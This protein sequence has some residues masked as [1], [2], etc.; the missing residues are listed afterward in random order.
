MNKNNDTKKMRQF[1]IDIMTLRMRDDINKGNLDNFIVDFLDGNIESYILGNKVEVN[2]RWH[3]VPNDLVLV[4]RLL[5]RKSK[6]LLKV[7]SEL[8]K[9]LGTS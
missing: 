8:N 3:F 4:N 1:L 7:I 2:W 6:N 5:G 9:R